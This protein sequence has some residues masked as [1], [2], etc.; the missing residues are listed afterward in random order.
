MFW[1]W[2]C[3]GLL[4][5]LIVTR[6]AIV[7]SQWYGRHCF[8]EYARTWTRHPK[9]HWQRECTVI[10]DRQS[11]DSLLDSMWFVTH[12]WEITPHI[13]IDAIVLLVQ[14]QCNS[15]NARAFGPRTT[16][17]VDGLAGDVM[18]AWVSHY[19]VNNS[20]YD[21]KASLLPRWLYICHKGHM[22]VLDKRN[23][24]WLR[25]TVRQTSLG[26][27]A[28]AGRTAGPLRSAPAA[29]FPGDVCLTVSRNHAVFLLYPVN[30]FSSHIWPISY[31]SMKSLKLI[32]PRRTFL[33]WTIS[34]DSLAR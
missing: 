11:I 23:T 32:S 10:T 9:T 22:F 12:F 28:A 4:W 31:E 25:D 15:I 26:K 13:L 5:T 27:S 17:R 21:F 3:H 2:C 19:L 24:A 29:D 6:D 14:P 18:R 7:T 34:Q 8:M 30:H 16:Y 33:D 20:I 1:V